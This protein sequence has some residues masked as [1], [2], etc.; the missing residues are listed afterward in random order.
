MA[1]KKKVVRRAWSKEDI[2]TLKTMAKDKRGVAKIA[3]TLRR[4][5]GATA[6]KAAKEGISL[7]MWG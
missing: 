4:S 3:K 2:R 7:S 5:P 6:V 1:K